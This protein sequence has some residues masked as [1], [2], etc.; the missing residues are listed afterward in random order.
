MDN[1]NVISKGFYG[2]SQIKDFIS[3]KNH[4][5]L[6]NGNKNYL[7]IRFSND[8]NVVFDS[9]SFDIIQLDSSGRSIGKVFVEYKDIVFVY[10]FVGNFVVRSPKWSVLLV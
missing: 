10:T 1:E 2:F 7:S 9:F 3:V 5:F 8:S 6:N 4:M